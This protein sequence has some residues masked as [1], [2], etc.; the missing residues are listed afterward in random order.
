[1]FDVFKECAMMISEVGK[2]VKCL[3]CIYCDNGAC[4]ACTV[5][6]FDVLGREMA[7]FEV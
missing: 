3:Y 1:M 7:I 4:S 2:D 5:I 6:I